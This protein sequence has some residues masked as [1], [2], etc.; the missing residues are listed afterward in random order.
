MR[1]DEQMYGATAHELLAMLANSGG[2]ASPDAGD[3]AAKL[4]DTHAS[5]LA[6]SLFLPG[7]DNER[8]LLRQ[9]VVDTARQL[10]SLFIDH[11]FK[12][13]DAEKE[14]VRAAGP[15]SLLGKSDLLLAAPDGRLVV[16]DLKWGGESHRRE[17][18]KTG[19]ALQLAAYAFLV[20]DESAQPPVTGFYILRRRRL[21]TDT[22]GVLP[23]A[24]EL[25]FVPSKEV[26]TAVVAGYEQRFVEIGGGTI[27]AGGI[28]DAVTPEPREDAELVEGRLLMP[29]SCG[30]CELTDLCG[31]RQQEAE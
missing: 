21:M 4:F 10:A 24:E 17:S 27:V 16:I 31:R 22:V 26:W 13:V 18:L 2:L 7:A 29:A 9:T 28:A 1:V 19:T 12:L 15:F 23:N 30:F 20:A 6:T 14:R 8:S 3:Q 25:A 5:K 11:G